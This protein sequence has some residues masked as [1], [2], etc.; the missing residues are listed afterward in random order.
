MLRERP[1]SAGKLLSRVAVFVQL[2]AIL[3]SSDVA[4][5]YDISST[6]D[7]VIVGGGVSG[8]VV[9]NRLTEG[10]RSMSHTCYVLRVTFTEF[11]HRICSRR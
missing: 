6:Y 3:M 8:L 1:S 7:Y 9:A 10:G 5:A 11:R 4:L 2:W